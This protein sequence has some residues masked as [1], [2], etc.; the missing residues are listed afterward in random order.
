MASIEKRSS[1][2]YTVRW[3]VHGKSRRKDF[4]RHSEAQGFK[5]QLEADQHRGAHI[6]PVRGRQTFSAW[7][8]V[9]QAGRVGLRDTTRA[10]NDALYS[11]HIEPRWGHAK[12]AAITQPQVQAWVNDL[13]KSDLAAS[14]VSAIYQEFSRCMQA[15]VNARILNESSCIG[16][17]LPALAHNDM[18]FLDHDDI[19]KLADAIDPRYRALTILLA[20]SGLRIG[21]ATALRS[22]DVKDRSVT[23]RSTAVEVNGVWMEQPPKTRAGRRTVPLPQRVADALHEHMSTYPGDLVFTSPTGQL[24]RVST[25]RSRAFKSACKRAGLEGLRIHDLRHTAISLWIRSGVDLL[26]VKTWAGHTKS[27]FTI[28]KYGH[29]YETDDAA[30][31]DKLNEA[32]T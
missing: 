31:L 30:I 18:Q 8:A 12:L 28:D 17:N 2:S 13:A 9:W 32:I 11:K 29:L 22:Q 25:F 1:G 23:V 21:E 10:K 26:R 19:A 5:R 4:Q 16:V 24:V 7:A 15:A 27:T 6:D 14:T 20:Y 3:R